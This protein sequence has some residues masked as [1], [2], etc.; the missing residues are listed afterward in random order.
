MTLYLLPNVLDQDQ[1]GKDVFLPVVFD[2][3]SS[4]QGLIAESDRGGRHFLRR[5][6]T[7]LP[8][9]TLNEHTHER[10]VLALTDP[11]QR[12]EKWGL[13]S[14]AG[15]PCVADPGA[16]LVLLCHQKNIPV[17]AIP[18]PSSIILILMLSGLNSQVFTFHGYLPQ[19]KTALITK[20]RHMEKEKGSHI[21]IETPYR[22]QKLL[23][24]LLSTL[25]P[26]TY[27]CIAWNLTTPTQGVITR[28]IKE[29]H[30]QPVPAL[31]GVP[32]IFQLSG[33]Y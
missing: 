29:W 4:L 20:I 1:D 21:F 27:L 25:S 17:V 22:N 6:S 33:S 18:G 5:F 30:K 23:E 28:S 10:D 14:D 32:A 13:I 8:I 9:H 7:H 2:I 12:G 11:L 31:D 3:V 26:S 24:T 16:R 15:V 19:D